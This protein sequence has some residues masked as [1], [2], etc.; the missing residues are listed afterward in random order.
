MGIFFSLWCK[1]PTS[2]I[3]W[4]A[5]TTYHTC[6]FSDQ[7]CWWNS[8]WLG[9]K[10]CLLGPWRCPELY[11]FLC[12]VWSYVVTCWITAKILYPCLVPL[13]LFWA[14]PGPPIW[15]TAPSQGAGGHLALDRNKGTILGWHARLGSQG[16][17]YPAEE[18]EV[19]IWIQYVV[20][21]QV[22]LQEILCW[23]LPL[24]LNFTA[25]FAE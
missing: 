15:H 14:C 6:S 4:K 13:V 3:S 23:M 2:C 22:Q 17:C 10:T 16:S 21:K 9:H 25:W 8:H 5:A 19:G 7:C 1:S 12:G 24:C 11:L 20:W 18:S